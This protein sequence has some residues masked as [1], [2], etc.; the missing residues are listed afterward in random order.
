MQLKLELCLLL[1]QQWLKHD[2]DGELLN[3][4]LDA[5][6]LDGELEEILQDSLLDEQLLLLELI[7]V[8]LK[9]ELCIPEELHGLTRDDDG[10]LHEK[11]LQDIE[12]LLCI[13]LQELHILLDDSLQ[14]LYEQ[15]D[16]IKLEDKIEH[17]LQGHAQ[18]EEQLRL[19]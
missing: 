16:D 8:Q 17:E 2:E 7:E 5:E 4:L 9:L 6:L 13:L 14:L 1:E 12:L 10:L 3:E 18:L 15:H 11:L 19:L